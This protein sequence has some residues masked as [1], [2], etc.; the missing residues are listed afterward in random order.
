VAKAGP[1]VVT[2]RK[3]VTI[4][5]V[6]EDGSTH[7]Y[8][9]LAEAPPEMQAAFRE[10]E[11]ELSKEPPKPAEIAAKAA[12]SSGP[13]ITR[14]SISVYKIKDASGTERTYHSLEELPP[15][16]RAAMERA[17]KKLGL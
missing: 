16:I 3:T 6:D 14:K 13:I 9:S 1:H 10:M 11:S 7:E 12:S 17:Q 4:K 2:I 8:H 15:E 5:S